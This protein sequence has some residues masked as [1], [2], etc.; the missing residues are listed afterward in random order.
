M[1]VLQ[2]TILLK[3]GVV[4][5]LL[6]VIMTQLKADVYATQ[7]IHQVE[8][9][10]YLLKNVLITHIGTLLQPNASAMLHSNM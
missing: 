6:I 1:S 4:L 2:P 7:D 9:V 5:V 8:A 10:V 3:L